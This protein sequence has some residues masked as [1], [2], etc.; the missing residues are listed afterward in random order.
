M[1]MRKFVDLFLAEKRKESGAGEADASSRSEAQTEAQG[2][3]AQSG[4]PVAGEAALALEMGETADALKAE[5]TADASGAD[6]SGPS[7]A[8]SDYS[9]GRLEIFRRYMAQWN[10]TGHDGMGVELVDGSLSVHA[11]NTYLQVIH[12][13]GLITGLCYLLV[14]AVSLLQ[15]F[16]YA[17]A[18]LKG[19]D[20]G[21]EEADAY[22]ALPLAIFLAFAVAGLVEWLFHPCNPLGFSTM[23]VLTPL[24]A[25]QNRGRRVSRES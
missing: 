9:N 12:D 7:E 6:Y 23:A 25:F 22:A 24:L 20:D 8:E 1:V 11:H 19:K 3:A 18:H 15:M 2:E 16:R 5:E 4:A 14:G 21:R 13:H 10:L 17:Y